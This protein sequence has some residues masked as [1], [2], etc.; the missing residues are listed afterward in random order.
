MVNKVC[1]CVCVCG[2]W[3]AVLTVVTRK[4]SKSSLGNKL[5][6]SNLFSD[7]ANV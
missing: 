3:A 1:V 5:V 7:E 2:L 4:V 6:T